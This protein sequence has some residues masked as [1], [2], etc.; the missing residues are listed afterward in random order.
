MTTTLI[1]LLRKRSALESGKIGREQLLQGGN[2]GQDAGDAD[3]K[4][5]QQQGEAEIDLG[6]DV[7][8]KIV[9][10]STRGLVGVQLDDDFLPNEL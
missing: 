10:A 7:K 4:L 1:N 6:I 9:T 3:A 2:Q 5:L 8:V